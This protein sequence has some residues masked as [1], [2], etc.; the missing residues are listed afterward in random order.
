MLAFVAGQRRASSARDRSRAEPRAGPLRPSM[1]S[2]ARTHP[3]RRHDL[4]QY[5]NKR[6]AGAFFL[7]FAV[8]PPRH[9]QSRTARLS[10]PAI[11][12]RCSAV[13]PRRSACCASSLVLTRKR[14]PQS[15]R[16][17]LSWVTQWWREPRPP[18]GLSLRRRS[19]AGWRCRGSRSGHGS[20]PRRAS[21]RCR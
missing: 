15:A 7:P 3:L 5:Y 20:E 11:C 8:A 13:R 19:S 21:S 16:P 6:A 10:E 17:F 18:P 9:T 14:A 2:T 4:G 1:V 12:T